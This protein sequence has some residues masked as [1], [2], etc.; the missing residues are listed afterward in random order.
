MLV[1]HAKRK[2]IL[3]AS[4]RTLI[5]VTSFGSVV[6]EQLEYVSPII[7]DHKKLPEVLSGKTI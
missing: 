2:E 1:T 6:H 7:S 5:M 3:E 4:T